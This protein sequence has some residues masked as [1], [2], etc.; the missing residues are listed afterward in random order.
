MIEDLFHAVMV[1]EGCEAPPG[2]TLEAQ[3]EAYI[4]AWQMLHDTGLAYKLQGWFGRTA[5]NLLA[6]GIITDRNDTVE[7]GGEA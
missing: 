2:D 1:A 4:Q 5:R 7:T 6:Q 3:R